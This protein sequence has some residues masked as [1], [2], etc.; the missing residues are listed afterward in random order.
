MTEKKRY[1]SNNFG[2]LKLIRH[3]KWFDLKIHSVYLLIGSKKEL[4]NK[5]SN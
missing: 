2:I 3:Q 5:T 1:K 4:A